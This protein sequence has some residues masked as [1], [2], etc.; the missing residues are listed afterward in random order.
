MATKPTEERAGTDLQVG[1]TLDRLA[2]SLSVLERDRG[3]I[4]GT[5]AALVSS[6][7][8]LDGRKAP[9][10]I[11]APAREATSTLLLRQRSVAR[12][13]GV[14]A[15]RVC[16]CVGCESSPGWRVH[17]VTDLG[18]NQVALEPLSID[19]CAAHRFESELVL[20]D[21]RVLRAMQQRLASR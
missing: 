21:G 2:L 14:G 7:R 5:K 1:L 19:V 16:W 20:A 8:R 17:I 13:E 11:V 10:A 9:L 15:R 4:Q 6:Q 12:R 3:L 18:G